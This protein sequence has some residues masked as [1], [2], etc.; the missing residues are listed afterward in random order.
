MKR[1]IRA[2]SLYL[3][4]ALMLGAVLVACTP[5]EQV[6]EG[7]TTDTEAVQDTANQTE[8]EAQPNPGFTGEEYE[9]PL[10]DG[11]NQVV[12]Y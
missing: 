11:Y 1:T 8:S 3:V 2:I 7:E 12:F 4:L 9:L 10:E 5:G 6:P